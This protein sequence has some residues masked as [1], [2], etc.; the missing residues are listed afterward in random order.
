MGSRASF[1]AIAEKFRLSSRPRTAPRP[2][3][4]AFFQPL[5]IITPSFSR[6]HEAARP[7]RVH[8][9]YTPASSIANRP[10]VPLLVN[11][12]RCHPLKLQRGDKRQTASDVV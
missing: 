3:N 4:P 11:T 10:R 2:I 5:P 9:Q 12:L 8:A 1:S 6:L 7:P